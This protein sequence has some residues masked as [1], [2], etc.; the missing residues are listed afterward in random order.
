VVGGSIVLGSLIV[1]R[2]PSLKKIKGGDKFLEQFDYEIES[3]P[4]GSTGIK[5][6]ATD[7]LKKSTCK[8]RGYKRNNICLILWI[9]PRAM[10]RLG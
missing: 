3:R 7:W 2:D 8:T 9:Y 6:A 5:M 4:E 1:D 10:P